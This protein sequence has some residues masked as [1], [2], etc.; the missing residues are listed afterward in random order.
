M[1]QSAT[2]SY[3]ATIINEAHGLISDMLA[4]NGLPLHVISGLKA[5]SALLK[6][7]DARQ[8]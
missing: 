2:S 8:Q 5:V 1:Q 3:E 4:D 6:V 7:S